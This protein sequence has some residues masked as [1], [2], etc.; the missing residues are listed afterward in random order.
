LQDRERE[1]LR[2]LGATAGIEKQLTANEVK[3]GSPETILNNS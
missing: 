3:A 2:Q 1:D